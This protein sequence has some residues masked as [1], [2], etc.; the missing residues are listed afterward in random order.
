MNGTPRYATCAQKRAI[1]SS[2]VEYIPV[3]ASNH[4]PQASVMPKKA[5]LTRVK[6]R[7]ITRDPNPSISSAV[8]NT[9]TA[10]AEKMY[11][12]E[13]KIGTRFPV[14][15]VERVHYCGLGS[16]LCRGSLSAGRCPF[17]VGRLPFSVGPTEPPLGYPW[18]NQRS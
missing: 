3:N 9:G 4:T 6:R 17:S 16:R 14:C 5:T 11:E 10:Y 12:L 7:I 15:F 13:S 1:D 18:S 8:R 2:R